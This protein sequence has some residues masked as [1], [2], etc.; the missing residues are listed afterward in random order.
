MAKFS[1]KSFAAAAFLIFG[2]VASPSGV[3]AAPAASSDAQDANAALINAKLAE[4][5]SLIKGVDPAIFCGPTFC[6]QCKNI[7]G[8]GCCLIG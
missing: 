6:S 5:N 3:H 4:L 1:L 2:V 8:C 7:G